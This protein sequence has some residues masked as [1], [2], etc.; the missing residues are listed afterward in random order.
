MSIVLDVIQSPLVISPTNTNHIWN[1]RYSG[2]TSLSNLQYIVDIYPRSNLTS[3]SSATNND[4]AVRLKLRPNS[5]GNAIFDLVEITRNFTKTNVLFTGTTYPYIN[6][7]NQ[8]NKIIPLA[9][10]TTTITY[11]Q[12]NL[13]PDGSPNSSLNQYWHINQYKVVLGVSYQSGGTFVEDIVYT[14]TTQPTP[15]TIFPGVD[16]KLIP[17][18]YLSAATINN[19]G[20]NWFAIDNQNHLYYDLFRFKYEVGSDAECAPREFFNAGGRDYSTLSQAGITTHRVRRRLHHPDCPIIMSFLDGYNPYF[21]NNNDR[22]VIRGAL[23]QT[24]PYTYSAV[25]P[26][27]SITTSGINAD[28]QFKLGVFYL[29]YNLTSGNT[30]NSIPTDSKKVS[31]YLANN[32]SAFSARTSEVM[33]FYMQDRSCINNPVHLLFLNGNGMW[34]TYTLGGKS[35]ETIDLKRNSYRQ[36]TSLNKA[37]YNVGS[38]SRGTTQFEIDA[39]W[40]ID[41]ETWYMSQNDVEIIK[42]LFMSP[43][44]FIIDGSALDKINCISSIADCASCLNEIRLYEYLIPI[45]ISDTSFQIWNKNYQ[46]LFQYKMSLVYSGEKRFR[47][48]G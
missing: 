47:T 13:W 19:Q 38:W 43:E 16:N 15:I 25:T 2:Y 46:K 40:K 7:A 32:S 45:T 34:D 33:E 4:R 3:F 17:A 11:D 26:N 44:V 1:V 6:Y 35:I 24:D 14:A 10:G 39:N 29:N 30:L 42:E 48:Q 41:A 31:F 21:T 20:A 22:L 8:V 37:F 9:D 27:T 36:E 18:P 12:A 28:A 5:Y 23:S